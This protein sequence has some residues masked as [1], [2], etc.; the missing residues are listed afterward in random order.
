MSWIDICYRLK[1]RHQ[2]T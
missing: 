2:V 1:A